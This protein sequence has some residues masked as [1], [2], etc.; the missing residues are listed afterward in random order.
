[1]LGV[2]SALFL[3]CDVCEEGEAS[4]IGTIDEKLLE[5]FQESHGG[6]VKQRFGHSIREFGVILLFGNCTGKNAPGSP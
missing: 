2:R 3:F 6:G 4:R 1:M 5:T